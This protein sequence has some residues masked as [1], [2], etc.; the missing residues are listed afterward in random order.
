MMYKAK[1]LLPYAWIYFI[2]FVISGTL[3]I[4][5]LFIAV[6]L[7]NLEKAKA[8]RLEELQ[9]PPNRETLLAELRQT[10]FALERLQHQ[11]VQQEGESR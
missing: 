10:Q 3:V 5:N 9:L 1:E 4:V 11:L 7:N 2:S 8:E 6:M